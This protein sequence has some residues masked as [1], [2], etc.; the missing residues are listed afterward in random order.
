MLITCY[1]RVLRPNAQCHF[2]V[3]WSKLNA[4]L[5]HAEQ[6]SLR[7]CCNIYFFS[8]SLFLSPAPLVF[9][10][11]IVIWDQSHLNYNVFEIQTTLTQFVG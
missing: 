4:F 10:E 11:A 7:R 8:L 3:R 2:S 1:I 6:Q 9:S 5:A